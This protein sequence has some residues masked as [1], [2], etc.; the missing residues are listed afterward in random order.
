MG[1]VE[2]GGVPMGCNTIRGHVTAKSPGFACGHW[3]V[4]T[5]EGAGNVVFYPF[6]SEVEASRFYE[7]L[8][9]SRPRILFDP[10]ANELRTGGW[11]PF[12]LSTIRT[13][14]A[15]NRCGVPA[16]LREPATHTYSCPCYLPDTG[17]PTPDGKLVLAKHIKEGD[18]VVDAGG[19]VVSV[20]FVR[21][22]PRQ[23]RELVQLGTN[24]GNLKVSADHRIVVPSED[25]NTVTRRASELHVGDQVFMGSLVRTLT[26]AGPPIEEGTELFEVTFFPDSGV[27]AFV[28]PTCG[29][30]TRGEPISAE[31]LKRFSES[32]LLQ[33]VPIQYND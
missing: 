1:E 6:A 25:N 26:R 17:F 30:R 32:D 29:M 8:F 11:N 16:D 10:A 22:H 13:R 3:M 5:E 24:R 4:V 20:L 7:S 15:S 28:V 27:E 23:K 2:H 19:K 9:S 12:A 21:H 14:V 33:A 31:L 18:K